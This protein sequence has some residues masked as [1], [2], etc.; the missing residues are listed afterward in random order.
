MWLSRLQG[1]AQY[2]E[3]VSISSGCAK[4]TRSQQTFLWTNNPISQI[5]WMHST[6]FT[7]APIWIVD[8]LASPLFS[9]PHMSNAHCL[10]IAMVCSDLYF[11]SSQSRLAKMTSLTQL[12]DHFV[13]HPW[14]LRTHA[15]CCKQNPSEFLSDVRYSLFVKKLWCNRTWAWPF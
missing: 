9:S 1:I 11:K 15:I 8:P 14:Q 12:M 2:Q 6:Q 4:R 7:L 13:G 5:D 10:C 3:S